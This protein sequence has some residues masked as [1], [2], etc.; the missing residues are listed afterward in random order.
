MPS[1]SSD[2]VMPVQTSAKSR[3]LSGRRTPILFMGEL[4]TAPRLRRES[5]TLGARDQDVFEELAGPPAGAPV[6][7]PAQALLE[8]QARPVEDL[9]VEVAAVAD[10]DHDRR[11]GTERLARTREYRRDPFAVRLDRGAVRP[12]CRGADLELAQVIE[13]EQLVRRA[14]LLVVVDQA[15]VGRR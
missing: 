9:R 6:D 7:V 1:P 8:A 4:S 14:V 12:T 3:I 11:A 10:D 13:T 15:W 5:Y 2:T